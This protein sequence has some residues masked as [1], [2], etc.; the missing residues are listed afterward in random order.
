MIRRF[1]PYLL[2]VTFLFLLLSRISAQTGPNITS[3]SPSVIYTGASTVSLTITGSGFAPTDVLCLS[4][5][6]GCEEL[7]VTYVSSTELTSQLSASFLSSP[8]TYYFYVLDTSDNYGSNYVEFSVVN[9]VPT[10]SSFS[11]PSVVASST[12]AAIT[13]N[14]SF[15]QGA[16][17]QWNGKTIATTFLNSGQLQFTPTKE[18]LGSAALIPITVANPSPGGISE[19]LNFDVTYKTTII[20]VDLPANDIVWDPY[21]QLLYAS[22]PSSYGPNGNSIA[23]INPKTGKIT[24][25][26]YAGSEPHPLALSSDSQ[27]L[28]AGLNGNGSVQRLILPHFTPDIDVSLGTGGDGINIAGGIQVSPS[29]DHIFAV[30]ESQTYCCNNVG[31]Y[32]FQDSTQ[33][34]D[35]VTNFYDGFYNII[36]ANSGT[37]YGFSGNAVA[38]VTV[39][40][41]GG[42][43]VTQWDGLVQGNEIWYANGLIYGNGG[44]VLNPATGLL[45][46][47]YDLG[48]SECCD[49]SYD[50]LLPSPAFNRLFAVGTTPFLG[51]LGVT[52]YDLDEFTPLAAASLSQFAGSTITNAI[53]WGTDGMAMIVGTTGTN[54]P[55]QQVVLLTSSDLIEPASK[56]K[57]PVPAP[58]SLSPATVAHG[59]WNFILTI[60]GSN[61]APGATVTWNGASLTTAYVSAT[62]LNVYVPY[63]DVASAGTAQI[64]VKNPSPGGGKAAALTFTID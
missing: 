27:Y 1:R 9:L 44:Q 37:V 35:A 58:T 17:V 50:Q 15:M 49:Y 62:Q 63:T 42:T 12:P 34:P 45:L 36:F 47:T 38:Q 64:V 8:Y 14:G 21:S 41:N 55:P 6:Y 53:P 29:S 56:T 51:T 28:Y 20:T 19:L 54:P 10:I 32:F 23:V 26:Y 4:G 25:Y 18:D 22:V 61:F 30:N 16:T 39:N 2:S 31:I 52:A 46:G 40:S 33:L 43:L 24:G 48:P 57:N 60:S 3:I 7:L 11:P 13:V 59:G 5:Y